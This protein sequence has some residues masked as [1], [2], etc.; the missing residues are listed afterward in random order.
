MLSSSLRLRLLTILFAA[1]RRGRG[2]RLAA[3]HR[4]RGA[5]LADQAQLAGAAGKHLV[6]EL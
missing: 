4:A 6:D 1:A 3:E 5:L 2:Q